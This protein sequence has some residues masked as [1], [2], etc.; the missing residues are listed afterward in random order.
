MIYLHYKELYI[1]VSSL[2][3][4]TTE[5]KQ[6]HGTFL[7]NRITI[8]FFGEVSTGKG[9]PLLNK[10]SERFRLTRATGTLPPI[11]F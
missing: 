4:L 8:N 3:H 10:T 2:K 6:K 9:N 5:K 11:G 1:H 7:R